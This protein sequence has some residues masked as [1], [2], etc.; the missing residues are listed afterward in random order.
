[1]RT[2][3][4]IHEPL[5]ARAKDLAARTGQ[6]LSDVVNDA[7]L[8]H[9]QAAEDREA[10]ARAERKPIELPTWGKPGGGLQ[11]GVDINNNAALRDLL[12][13]DAWLDEDGNL[14]YRKMR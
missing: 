3:V 7:L 11:P 8:L 6:R 9:T 5:L 13:E 12:D 4:D 10:R 14:D 2:T 1:M